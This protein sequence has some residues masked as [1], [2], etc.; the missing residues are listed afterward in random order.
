M[1]QLV[2]ILF[3]LSIPFSGFAQVQTQPQP[4]FSGPNYSGT[5]TCKGENSQ[6]GK[7]AVT[8]TL[9]L[10]LVS[11]Y[12]KFG[13]YEYTAETENSVKFYGNAVSS[14]NQ[15]ATSFYID[16]Q[17]RRGEPTTGLATVKR[18]SGGRWSF[19]NLYFEPDDFGGN[20]GVETCTM[21]K[22]DKTEIRKPE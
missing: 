15:L 17:R 10:N 5:Y 20:Y 13:V 18:E 22:P 11:S 12:A 16:N 2:A 1:K 21:N 9:R 8:V 4:R 14:G 6:V 7:Y 3:L 19:R